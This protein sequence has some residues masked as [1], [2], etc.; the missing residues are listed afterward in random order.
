MLLGVNFIEQ[1]EVLSQ[2]DILNTLSSIVPSST[3][4]LGSNVIDEQRKEGTKLIYL[5]LQKTDKSPFQIAELRALKR[6]LSRKIKS[7]I[8]LPKDPSYVIDEEKMRGILLLSKELTTVHNRSEAII[9]FH[10]ESDGHYH[11]SVIVSRLQKPEEKEIELFST[12]PITVRKQ[13]RKVAGILEKRYIKEIYL[14]DVSILTDQKSIKEARK[15]LFQFIK[16]AIPNLHDYSGGTVSRK[17]ENLKAF[18][19]MLK[20]PLENSP[21]EN[22]FYAITPPYMQSLTPPELLKEHFEIILKALELNFAIEKTHILKEE[23]KNHIL[24]VIASSDEKDLEELRKKVHLG[25][26]DIAAF[27][28]KALNLHFFGLILPKEDKRKVEILDDLALLV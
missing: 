20:T 3:L 12:P 24:I 10:S 11:F 26:D 19:S 4:L 17:Y 9:Q 21:I 16:K 14:Y 22:Y 18:K 23:T 25:K 1:G 13:E 28:L 6:L 7:K 27:S 5:E 8:H 2:E 15:D